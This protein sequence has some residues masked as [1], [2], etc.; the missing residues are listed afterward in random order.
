MRHV[1]VER[2][3][4]R[5]PVMYSGE[6]KWPNGDQIEVRGYGASDP[7][8]DV[9]VSSVRCIVR[10]GGSVVVCRNAHDVHHAWPGGRRERGESLA[11][12]AVREV[13]EETGWLIDE[14]SLV[15]VGWLHLEN[16]TPVPENHPYPNPDAFHAVF[17]GAADVRAADDWTDTEG[18]ELSSEL[19][20]VSLAAD[21][22]AD[23]PA[24]AAFL[25]MLFF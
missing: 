5:A 24:C 9:V 20:P 2:F 8:P 15:Q 3:L 19:V 4:A 12:T 18:Y 1:D 16:V 23:D 14:G 17:V 13:H 11:E 22:V 25:R 10:V 7:L 6:G 21:M